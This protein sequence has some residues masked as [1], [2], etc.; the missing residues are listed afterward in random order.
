MSVDSSRL[1]HLQMLQDVISRM[2]NNSF[3]IKGWSI[4]VIAALLGFAVSDHAD[5][6]AYVA[7]LPWLAFWLLDGFFLRQER[8]FRG[9]YDQC[10]Q[11][12][13]TPSD[14]SMDTRAIPVASWLKVTLSRTLLLFHGLLGLVIGAVILAGHYGLLT[15]QP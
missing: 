2:A 15:T 6:M 4:T 10:R 9:L 11:D 3:M 1:Q 14:F 12:L 5:L 13:T 7:L 8:L